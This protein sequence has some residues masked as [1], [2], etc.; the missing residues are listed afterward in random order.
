MDV[1]DLMNSMLS[2]KSVESGEETA[3]KYKG[4]WFILDGDHRCNIISAFNKEGA[5]GIFAYFKL[6]LVEHPWSSG[7]SND[8]PS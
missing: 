5:K 3:L 1:F 6:K 2:G 4:E 8:F 7:D